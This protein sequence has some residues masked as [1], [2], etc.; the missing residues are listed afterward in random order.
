MQHYL[1]EDKRKTAVGKSR[2]VEA[3]HERLVMTAFSVLRQRNNLS[4]QSSLKSDTLNCCTLI[5]LL[6]HITAVKCEL[7]LQWQ[8]KW[9]LN[10]CKVKAS[11]V[12][13]HLNI[14]K[15]N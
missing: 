7:V 1:R 5:L 10:V 3:T 12:H 8:R 14:Q 6:D 11:T 15:I 4:F 9:I 2:G 13:E